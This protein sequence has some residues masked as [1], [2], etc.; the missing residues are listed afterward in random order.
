M[1]ER[2]RP[3]QTRTPRSRQVDVY[4]T[5]LRQEKAQPELLAV[6]EK[7]G[8]K[9][10]RGPA[11]SFNEAHVIKALEIIANNKIVGRTTISN[12]LELGIGT[13]RT[14]LK[15]LKKEEHITSSKHGYALSEQGKDLYSK[16]QSKISDRIQVPN[17]PFAVG[18][19]VVAVLVRDRGHCV[20]RGVEQRNTAIRAGASGASTLVFSNNQIILPS[21]KKHNQEGIKQLQ[22]I[23]T[24]KLDPQ[25][26]DALILG[27]GQNQTNAEIG[28]LMAALK[29][30]KQQQTGTINLKKV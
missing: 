22:E 13:T 1:S 19:V 8:S 15:H 11:P 28:A 21:K 16:L 29:L 7:V 20:G 5:V 18:P 26:N 23:V 9:I 17:N 25:E 2:Q 10:A 14:I 12:K 6:L 27:S 30:L 3:L 4:D 24:A